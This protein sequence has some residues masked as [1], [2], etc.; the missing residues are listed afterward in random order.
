MI[1]ILGGVQEKGYIHVIFPTTSTSVVCSNGTKALKVPEDRLAGGGIY[2]KYP[3]LEHGRSPAQ[4]GQT[5]QQRQL[6]YPLRDRLR[7]WGQ[8]TARQS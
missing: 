3:H 6:Q 5:R 8:T 1:Y 7:R 4:M 2:L